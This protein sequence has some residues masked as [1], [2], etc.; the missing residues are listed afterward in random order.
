MPVTA[1]ERASRLNLHLAGLAPLL[2]LAVALS[3]A[4][5]QATEPADEFPF[6]TAR[7]DTLYEGDEEFRFISFNIPNLH[8]VEDDMRF[9]QALPFRWPTE[10]EIRDAL[11]TV[12]QMGGRVV[13]SYALS[14]RKADDPDG[15][16]RHVLRPGEFDESAFEV[17]DTVLAVARGKR[18]RL[19]V[20]L[21]DN[22]HWWGGIAEHAAFRGK[23]REEFWKDRQLIADFKQTIRFVVERVNTRT[24]IAY[25]DDPT[26]LA[27]ETGNELAS[28]HRW[29]RE[30]AAYI[31]ELDKNHLV[32]DGRQEEILERESINNPHIDLL[33]THHYEKDPRRMIAHIEK[34][35][36][37]ARGKK[38]YHVGEFGFLSTTAMTAVMDTIID[39]GV[40][41]G[42]VWSLRYHNEDGGF[43]WHHEP[44][45]G[46]LFKAYHWPGFTSGA[47]YDETEFLAAM[48]R[49]AFEIRGLVEPPIEPP[50]APELIE[51]T[52]GG[53]VTWRGS[54]GANGYDIERSNGDADW[55][56]IAYGIS[57][58]H[59]QYRPL[60]A[61]ETTLPGRVYSYRVRARNLAGLSDPSPPFGPVEISHRTF[62]DELRTDSK[63]FLTEGTLLFRTNQ[64]RRYK[65][66]AHGLEARSGAA[67]IYHAPAPI[68]GGRVYLFADA[69]GEHLSFRVSKNG[70]RF[71]SFKPTLKTIPAGDVATYGYRQPFIYRLESLPEGVRYLRIEFQG[72]DARLT[73]VE[74]EY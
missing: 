15:M 9:E 46:D 33:Q 18:I 8:Y 35:A 2:L 6:I 67:A 50:A 31:K 41:G 10:F 38:P 7:G 59:V 14:V 40:V 19:I 71:R 11:E 48:R 69:S 17:L 12:N 45:G 30:M 58:A 4:S 53:L 42:L 44:S 62:V 21:V 22:W 57:D 72:T 5:A 63:M 56:T 70:E 65:E 52:K 1:N 3:A 47:A 74:L 37:K 16:P 25:K 54:A 43:Y 23:R 36:R 34:S 20:P 66:D 27:W 49:R 39:E 68:T 51:V 26:I 55:R 61:D 29:T 28:P 73:R 64:A 13:R 60:Y 24:G 32:L